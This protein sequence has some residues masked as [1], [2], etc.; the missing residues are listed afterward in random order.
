MELTLKDAKSALE[1]SP[2][3]KHWIITWAG[4]DTT[5]YH[6]KIGI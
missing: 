3:L 5:F 4:Q 2:G 6:P 1:V